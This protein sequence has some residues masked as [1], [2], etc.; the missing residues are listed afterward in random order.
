M[1]TIHMVFRNL[2]LWL[3]QYVFGLLSGL[4]EIHEHTAKNE[5]GPQSSVLPCPV[6]SSI[7][8]MLFLGCLG[9]SVH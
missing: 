4:L 1:F 9:D 8:T 3:V 7:K 2:C 6:F 5:T